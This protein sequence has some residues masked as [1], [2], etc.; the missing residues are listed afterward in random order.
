MGNCNCNCYT[1]KEIYA[2]ALAA[3]H[4]ATNHYNTFMNECD[5]SHVREAFHKCLEQE[6]LI[7]EEVFESMHHKGY[8]PTPAA[9]MKK[10]D[11]VKQKFAQSAK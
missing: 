6:H 5:H 9:E 7:Q 8:Y 2:D 4:A 3:Q 10:I 1:E 11:E